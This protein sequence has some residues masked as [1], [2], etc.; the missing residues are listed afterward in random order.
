MST[1]MHVCYDLNGKYMGVY[2]YTEEDAI[3][4]YRHGRYKVEGVVW[5]ANVDNVF[6]LIT[7]NPYRAGMLP[8]LTR[9]TTQRKG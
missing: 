6:E 8:A 1:T 3:P 4:T 7:D 9:D 5:S 2:Q